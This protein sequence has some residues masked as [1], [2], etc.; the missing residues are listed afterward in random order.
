MKL[1]E[2]KYLGVSVGFL[3]V[4]TTYVEDERTQKWFKEFDR[5]PVDAVELD[6]NKV[7]LGTKS[8]LEIEQEE[9]NNSNK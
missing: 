6:P 5:P 2:I 7:F 8:L 4:P 3:I 1:Y 9:L